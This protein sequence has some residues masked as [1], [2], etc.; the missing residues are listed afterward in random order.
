MRSN[1]CKE[2]TKWVQ[3]LLL[4]HLLWGVN[5]IKLWT[6]HLK[7]FNEPLC[8]WYLNHCSLGFVEFHKT[9]VLFFNF[10]NFKN[11]KV[12]VKTSSEKLSQ[13]PVTELRSRISWYT[14]LPCF[15]WQIIWNLGLDS[16]VNSITSQKEVK[17]LLLE[18]FMSHKVFIVLYLYCL[19]GVIERN[20]IWNQTFMCIFKFLWSEIQWERCWSCFTKVFLYLNFQAKSPL[21]ESVMQGFVCL[22][23]VEFLAKP[24]W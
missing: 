17:E 24:T 6:K 9:M 10:L 14:N 8:S 18:Y 4:D 22:C 7:M 23:F 5:F 15:L 19:F 21:D 3:K 13:W 2:I 16:C 11:V 20:E 1:N 12:H